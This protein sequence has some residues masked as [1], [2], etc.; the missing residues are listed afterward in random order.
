MKSLL[1]MLGAVVC[2]LVIALCA[3]LIIGRLA[4]RAR[5]DLT[6]HRLYTLSDGTRNILAKL[7]QPVRL[8]LYY[9]RTATMKGPQQIRYYNNYFLY[10]RDVLQEYV[11]LSGGKLTLE[12][13][14]PRPFSD[15]EQEAIEHGIK[16]FPISKNESFFFG[17]VAQTE[18]GKKKVIEF[19]E[20]GRQEFVEY[21]V[22]KLISSVVARDRRKIGVLSSLPVMGA[23]NLSPYMVQ[24]MRMQG[25]EPPQPWTIINDLRG[26]YEVEHVPAEGGS[27]PDGIDYLMVIQPK[28][29]EE[30]MLFAIDQYVMKGGKLLVFV[31]P[32]C[33]VEQP[34]QDF[35]N[36]YAAMSHDASSNLNRLLERWG[37]E[38]LPEKIA[39]DPRL[40]TRVRLRDRVEPLITYLSLNS[41]CV[42]RDEVVT[43]KLHAIRMLFAG[44]LEKAPEAKTTVVPLLTTTPTGSTWSPK[45]PFEL[46]MP[47][48]AAITRAVGPGNERILLACRIT[49]KLKTSFPDGIAADEEHKDDPE[50]SSEDDKKAE[51]EKKD[52]DEKKEGEEKKE[53]EKKP[54]RIAAVQESSEDA[55][56]LVFADVDMLTD[57][58]AYQDTFFGPA[59]IGDN[60]SVVLNAIEFLA[61]TGDLIAI[62][63]RGRFGRP[64]SVVDD[65]ETEA[66]KATA[67]EKEAINEKIARYRKELEQLGASANDKNIQVVR[68]AA[69]EKRRALEN[70]IELAERQGRLVEWKADRAVRSLKFW[71]QFHNL[72]WAPASVLFIGIGLFI[73]RRVKA[74][75][76]AARRMES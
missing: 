22:S 34:P 8:R 26:E 63:S 28:N 39:A 17:L 23:D 75:Q 27:I 53:E 13:I 29:L 3:T 54:K 68:T 41:D 25:R 66:A 69:L 48:P 18:L 10:V 70:D 6:E 49:G 46:R 56:V 38:M 67:N 40:A 30:R 43:G 45:S 19:F 24:M 61:G 71:L 51:D 58:M 15:E 73:G 7:G 33:V 37:V 5:V 21:D 72:V 64:F 14:D 44:V 59:R 32:H 16:R 62:R 12:M 76:Y 9:A 57:G 2:I 20:P 65:I 42:N 31:D 74:R 50:A 52:G 36:P 4:G 35:R 1:R 47:D 60:A 55:A 11:A